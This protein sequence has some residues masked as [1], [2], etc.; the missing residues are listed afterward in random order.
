MAKLHM[1][2][3]RD[4]A[5]QAYMRPFVVPHKGGAVRGFMDEVRR[6]DSELNKHPEDYE[7]W[8]V[9]AFDEDT[10]VVEAVPH[11][12]LVRGKDAKESA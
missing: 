11:E 1:C 12:C 10:G 6:P 7:L 8:L 5:V 3:V 2:A 9:G 4:S